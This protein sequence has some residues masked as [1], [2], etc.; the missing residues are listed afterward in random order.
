[1][2]WI[3]MKY[4]ITISILLKKSFNYYLLHI[5]AVGEEVSVSYYFVGWDEVDK[6]NVI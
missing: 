4:I 1:M 6:F 2:Q 5:K 3:C